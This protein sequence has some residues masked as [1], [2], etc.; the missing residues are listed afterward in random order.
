MRRGTVSILLGILSTLVCWTQ[1]R[2]ASAD[3]SFT[4]PEQGRV[5]VGEIDG[6]VW[7]GFTNLRSRCIWKKLGKGS[8][9]EPL[10]IYGTDAGDWVYFVDSTTNFALCGETF[11]F[12]PPDLNRKAVHVEGRGGGDLLKAPDWIE[13]GSGDDYIITIAGIE[14]SIDG[15]VVYAGPGYDV[16]WSE[17]ITDSIHEEEMLYEP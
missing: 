14:P 7:L 12:N 11:T 9:Q 16:V 13:G 5:Y 10:A 6:D 8:L 15:V 17:N 4:L 2:V 3:F 1:P